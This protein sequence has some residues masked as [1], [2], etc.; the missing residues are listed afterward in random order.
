MS[1]AGHATILFSLRDNPATLVLF[2]M[3]ILQMRKLRLLMTEPDSNLTVNSYVYTIAFHPFHLYYFT[4]PKEPNSFSLRESR[5]YQPM[6]CNLHIPPS[7][8]VFMQ[9]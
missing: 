2:P 4:K 5:G 6:D 7:L 8:D 3:S 1:R 9:R